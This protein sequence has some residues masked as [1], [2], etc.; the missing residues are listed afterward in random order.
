MPVKISTPCERGF[1]IVNARSEK[2]KYDRY[3]Y[4]CTCKLCGKKYTWLPTYISMYEKSGCPECLH[5]ASEKK[6]EAGNAKKIEEWK[7]EI[8]KK[9]G[10]LIV[11]DFAGKKEAAKGYRTVPYM[12][13]LCEKCGQY[14]EIPLARL[15]SGG[16]K[17][18]AACAKKNLDIGREA[19]KNLYSKNGSTIY[20]VSER[21]K[22]NKNNASGFTGVS[23]IQ[24]INKYRSYIVFQR[25]QYNL[26]CYETRIEA[27]EAYMAAKKRLHGGFVEWYKENCPENWNKIQ[28]KDGDINV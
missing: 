7:Q 23:Y 19:I 11:V 9:Y 27:H 25:K 21:R 10:D 17:E 5:K 13:C 28:K 24:S 18:C 8:G 15:R 2:K 22:R 14:T 12:K 6:V 3:M 1:I 26:G 4:E 20:S 16:A